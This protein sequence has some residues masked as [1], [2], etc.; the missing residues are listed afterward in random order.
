MVPKRETNKAELV[1]GA[2][3]GIRRAGG[4]IFH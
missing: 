2:S 4:I 3:G 1:T